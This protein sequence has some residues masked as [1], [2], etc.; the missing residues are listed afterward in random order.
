[1]AND[2]NSENPLTEVAKAIGSSIGTAAN[3]AAELLRA[4]KT[5]ELGSVLKSSPKK[6]AGAPKAKA[7][8][9]KSVGR[10]VAAKT[11]SQK[12]TAKKSSAKKSSAKMKKSR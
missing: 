5:G 10:K 1:M 12:S 6:K 8:P 2:P 4:A 9:K 11:A 7:K 3:R